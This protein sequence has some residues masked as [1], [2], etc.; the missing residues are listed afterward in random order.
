MYEFLL[1]APL[2]AMACTCAVMIWSQKREDRG[3][4]AAIDTALDWIAKRI[5]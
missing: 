3:K 4:P 5:A 2:F 1:S